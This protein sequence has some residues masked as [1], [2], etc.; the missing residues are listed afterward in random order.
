MSLRNV[1]ILG[2]GEM[3]ALTAQSLET[4]AQAG[5]SARYVALEGDF[6]ALAKP[7]Q[8]LW[9][10]IKAELENE[11]DAYVVWAKDALILW[12][13]LARAIEINHRPDFLW[14]LP[15]TLEDGALSMPPI[16]LFK[17]VGGFEISLFGFSELFRFHHC[18]HA[19]ALVKLLTVSPLDTL[20]IGG[21]LAQSW[22]NF[23][24]VKAPDTWLIAPAD[25]CALTSIANDIE[26]HFQ[27]FAPR[28]GQ[29]L[30][31]REALDA[32][33]RNTLAASDFARS[34]LDVLGDRL[35]ELMRM[36]PYYGF[37]PFKAGQAKFIQPATGHHP[38]VAAAIWYGAYRPGSTLW[39]NALFAQG[40]PYTKVIDA[41]DDGHILG[42]TYAAQK[43]VNRL[44]CHAPDLQR[45]SWAQSALD[46]NARLKERVTITLDAAKADEGAIAVLSVSNLGSLWGEMDAFIPLDG[47]NDAAGIDK[48]IPKDFTV[49]GFGQPGSSLEKLT[50]LSDLRNF[51]AIILIHNSR[52][53]HLTKG[54]A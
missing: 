49:F 2:F 36:L 17:A 4:A 11:N 50:S 3:G 45:A 20:T 32:R 47:I 54:A 7:A 27:S 14:P 46:A 48:P 1:I 21:Y 16:S 37:W 15:L 30:M 41:T 6:S 8:S 24:S 44:I 39:W 12:D 23:E 26:T 34:N 25:E 29:W 40:M 9:T 28:H 43:T 33:S 52:V 22:E 10:K 51:A 13:R 35:P 42:L 5:I 31:E 18:V 53:H 38:A 19:R